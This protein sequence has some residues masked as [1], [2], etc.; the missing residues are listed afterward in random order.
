MT[1]GASSQLLRR[2]GVACLS[3]ILP[4]A[5]EPNGHP[6]RP[7]CSSG[8]L[9]RVA[10]AAIVIAAIAAVPLAPTCA[11][12][13]GSLIRDAPSPADSI[14]T[15]LPLI[16]YSVAI[17]AIGAAGTTTIVLPEPADEVVTSSHDAFS[18]EVAGPRLSIRVAAIE[19]ARR[20]ADLFVTIGDVTYTFELALDPRA[21]GRTF[22]AHESEKPGLGRPLSVTGAAARA[23]HFA[24]AV[25]FVD[26]A[27]LSLPPVVTSIGRLT[28]IE[29]PTS[30]VNILILDPESFSVDVRGSN[31]YVAP[32]PDLAGLKESERRGRLQVFMN[33]GA[34]FDFDLRVGPAGGH[35]RGVVVRVALAPERRV[36]RRRSP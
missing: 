14:P 21:G 24:P 23:E 1:L 32:S 26:A 28:R 7:S 20:G 35:H 22:E 25:M 4:V 11:A 36:L 3:I 8:A 19:P 17:V 18:V 6:G 30:P 29:L 13:P 2:T 9:A 34:V 5:L 33:G 10:S 16:P 31:L 27:A 12:W 15:Q